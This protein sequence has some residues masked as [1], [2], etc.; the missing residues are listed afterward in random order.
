MIVPYTVYMSKPGEGEKPKSNVTP[1]TLF[2]GPR[3]AEEN[4]AKMRHPASGREPDNSDAP[5]EDTVTPHD[6]SESE[7]PQKAGARILRIVQNPP[8]ES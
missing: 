2:S 4:E 7:I 1:I 3:K 6:I 8:N 5:Q